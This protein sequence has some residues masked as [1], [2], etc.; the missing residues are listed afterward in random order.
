VRPVAVMDDLLETVL[1]VQGFVVAG[2]VIVGLATLASAALVF[3]LSLRLRRRE[4][5][6]L[7]KIGGSRTAVGLVMVFE[8]VFTLSA[9]AVL[10]TALTLVTRLFGAEVIR[11]F[12]RM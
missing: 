12:M 2:A 1:T 3:L 4:I 6:T 7:S 8:I 5:E 11:A 9:S 10:A